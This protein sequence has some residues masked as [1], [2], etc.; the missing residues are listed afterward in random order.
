FGSGA[1]GVEGC[2]VNELPQFRCGHMAV[3]RGVLDELSIQAIDELLQV[4]ARRSRH[5]G[6]GE[7]IGRTLVFVALAAFHADAELVETALEERR[8]DGKTG[9]AETA[10]GLQPKVIEGSCEIV[11]GEMI[12]A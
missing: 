1:F 11:V 6:L 5:V 12:A 2:Y 9:N 4:L 3:T 10:A 7:G 8:F